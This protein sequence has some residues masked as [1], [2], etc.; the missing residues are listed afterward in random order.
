MLLASRAVY[1]CPYARALAGAN[2]AVL[3]PDR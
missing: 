1:F 3:D 2:L